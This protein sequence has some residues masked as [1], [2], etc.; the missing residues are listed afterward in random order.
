MISNANG[1]CSKCFSDMLIAYGDNATCCERGSTNQSTLGSGTSACNTIVDN[2]CEEEGLVGG[3]LVCT[4]CTDGNFLKANACVIQSTDSFSTNVPNCSVGTDSPAQKCL[5]CSTGHFLQPDGSCTVRSGTC[6]NGPTD[7]CNECASQGTQYIDSGTGECTNRVNSSSKCQDMYY[8]K[9]KDG[10]DRCLAGNE[11]SYYTGGQWNCSDLT[12]DS[13]NHPKATNDCVLYDY[14]NLNCLSCKAT[15]YLHTVTSECIPVS[16]CQGFQKVGS[17]YYCEVCSSTSEVI[18]PTTKKCVSR[19]SQAEC[20][21]FKDNSN[22]CLECN[23]EF[24]S[25][26]G[27]C[28]AVITSV[29]NCVLYDKNG[30][31][32]QCDAG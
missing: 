6:V 27:V 17:D 21:N 31:C 5:K 28:E 24:Y 1:T 18:D 16:K 23:D 8:K 14:D 30:K 20:S 7:N 19:T 29:T 26:D 3:S 11:T 25:K 32:K 13:V 2:K 4:R 10:C 12:L 22:D 9:F 15:H